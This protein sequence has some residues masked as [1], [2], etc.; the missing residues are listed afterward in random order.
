MT[1]AQNKESMSRR[2]LFRLS[3]FMLPTLP[4]M[5]M[6]GA[7]MAQ[8]PAAKAPAADAKPAAPACNPVP[9][10]DPV[11][12][13]IKYASDGSKVADRPAKMGVEGKNQTCENCQL[14]TKQ[15][16]QGLGKCTMIAA[17]CVSSQGW[18]TAWV[19]KA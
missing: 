1:A 7:A 11:A 13:A 4:L 18:C 9:E 14:F 19:K 6:A 12:K 17:G 3:A 16:N 5:A 15:G 2:E 8:A 10:T